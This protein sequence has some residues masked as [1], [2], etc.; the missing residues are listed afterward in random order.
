MTTMNLTISHRRLWVSAE[1]YTTTQ[2]VSTTNSPSNQVR[3]C[4]HVLSAKSQYDELTIKACVCL[5]LCEYWESVRRTHHQTRCVCVC[6]CA[7][8]NV[9]SQYSEL[10][11]NQEHVCVRLWVLRVCMMSLPLNHLYVCLCL[12]ECNGV[13]ACVSESVRRA[14]H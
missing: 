3:V 8:V 2:R 10:V 6:M 14:Y 5:C 12:C 13:C 7:C 11:I 4:I 9:T 1:R